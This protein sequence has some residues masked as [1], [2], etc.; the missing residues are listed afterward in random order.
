MLL[1][2]DF[3]FCTFLDQKLVKKITNLGWEKERFARSDV[4]NIKTYVHF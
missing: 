2:N 1:Q 4:K 3:P